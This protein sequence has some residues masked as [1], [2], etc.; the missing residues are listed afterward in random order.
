MPPQASSASNDT[1]QGIQ[2][3]GDS[4]HIS[5]RSHNNMKTLLTRKKCGLNYEIITKKAKKRVRKGREKRKERSNTVRNFLV[6][7]ESSEDLSPDE[8]T[9]DS[10]IDSSRNTNEATS[11]LLDNT[12]EAYIQAQDDFPLERVTCREGDNVE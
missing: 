12:D 10:T 5:V 3:K 9:D 1:S 2:G 7:A 8:D 11:Q 6:R 4:N